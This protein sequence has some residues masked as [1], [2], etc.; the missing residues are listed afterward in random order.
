M[1]RDG[2]AETETLYKRYGKDIEFI[3]IYTLE[4]HPCGV[5]S[6]YSNKEWTMKASW[7]AA[8][9]PLGQPQNYTERLTAASQCVKELGISP[10][11]LVDGMDNAV[12]C[13][14]GGAPNNAYLIGTN[15]KILA[16]HGWYQPAG[17]ELSITGY[18]KNLT[19]SPNP[20]Q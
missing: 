15:G 5:S 4:A 14:Y 9:N 18:L 16:K 1:Y 12:W 2:V 13:A 20:V 3:I 6:P 8:G 11:V 19:R 10:I 17:M 7:D